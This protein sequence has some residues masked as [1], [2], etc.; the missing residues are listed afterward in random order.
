M[1]RSSLGSA[2]MVGVLGLV[3]AGCGGGTGSTTT[4]AHLHV[5]LTSVAT[6]EDAAVGVAAF[7]DKRR[8]NWR[9]R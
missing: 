6:T 1:D 3:A 4:L 5:G 7:L 9:G 2:A 8:P